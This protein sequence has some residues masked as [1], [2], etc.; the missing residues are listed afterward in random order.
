MKVAATC[1]R[2]QRNSKSLTAKT[3]P[4]KSRTA[5]KSSSAA[6]AAFGCAVLEGETLDKAALMSGDHAVC[7]IKRLKSE[8]AVTWRESKGTARVSPPRQILPRAAR[9]PRAVAQPSPLP[10]YQLTQTHTAD[11]KIPAASK[12]IDHCRR[13]TN[14]ADARPPPTKREREE[15]HRRRYRSSPLRSITTKSRTAA[16]SSNAV[17]L[18]RKAQRRHYVLNEGVSFLALILCVLCVYCV[19]TGCYVKR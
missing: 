18:P 10:R 5:A 16:K 7:S 11:G 15:H 4:A 14:N 13:I 12:N 17:P 8:N 19:F 2:E 9:P 1:K 3:D 6:I